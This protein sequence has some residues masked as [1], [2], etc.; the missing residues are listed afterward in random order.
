[1]NTGNLTEEQLQIL[2][3]KRGVSLEE[4]KDTLAA[5]GKQMGSIEA[6]PP[7]E[8]EKKQETAAGVSSSADTSLESQDLDPFEKAKYRLDQLK[9]TADDLK[10]ID[11]LANSEPKKVPIMRETARGTMTST[12]KFYDSY[13][14][15]EFI[16]QAKK[17][18]GIDDE[19]A[20][21]AEAK[22]LYIDAARTNLIDERA[23]EILEDYDNDSYSVLGRLRKYAGKFGSIP[24]VMGEEE[25]DAEIGKAKLQTYFNEK[26]QAAQEQTD[27]SIESIAKSISV[28]D[29]VDARLN[30]LQSKYKTAPESIT[31]EDVEDYNNLMETRNAAYS[32]YEKAKSKFDDVSVEAETLGQIADLTGRTYDNL[33]VATNRITAATL[34]IASGVASV[35]KELTPN[36][37]SHRI[38]GTDEYA[39][40]FMAG[41]SIP[42]GATKW[43]D[44]T[45]DYL[46]EESEKITNQTKKRQALGE[47]SS[48]EDF[49]E[50]G[51]DLFSEQAVNTAITAGL[52]GAGLAIVSA[53]AAGNKFREMDIEIEGGEKISPL[54]FYAT[55]IMHGLGEYVTEKVSLDQFTA[56]RKGL[57]KAF[58][59]KGSSISLENINAAQAIKNWGIQTN[60][61]G[62]AE[63]SSQLIGN[64]ADKYVLGKDI[65]L[66]DGLS[67]SYFSGAIMS[68][69][70]FNAPALASDLTKVYTTGAEM[71]ANN[72]R[73]KRIV[74]ITKEIN[75]LSALNAEVE[76]PNRSRAI[77][78]LQEE[79]DNLVKEQLRAKKVNEDRLDQLSGADKRKLIDIES[80]AYR[81][82]KR[83]D[84]INKDDSISEASKKGMIERLAKRLDGLENQKQS[85]L[86]ES[87]L[88]KE[89]QQSKVFQRKA[90]AEAGLDFEII[91]GKDKADAIK[92]MQAKIDNSNLNDEQKTKLRE[93]VKEFEQSNANGAE[94]GADLG[95]PMSVV[96]MQDAKQDYAG[97]GR[98][99]FSHE[100]SH[101]SIFRKLVDNDADMQAL[102]KDTEKYMRRNYKG[103]G[104]RL[105]RVARDYAGSDPAILAEEKLAAMV[106]YSRE[107]NV[108]LD[109]TIQ[110][111][112]LGHWRKMF[113]KGQI[114]SIENG[115][116]VWDA[117]TAFTSSFEQ[118]EL[119]QVTKGILE[120]KIKANTKK[121]AQDIAKKAKFSLSSSA[122]RA[123][124]KLD[125][126]QEKGDIDPFDMD[127]VDELPG[128]ISAQVQPYVN[129]GLQLDREEL[130]QDVMVRIYE[131][132]DIGKFDGRG[133]L[134]G[135]LNGRIKF[136]ILDAFKQNPAIV[137]D[138]GDV[139]ADGLQGKEVQKLSV[140]AVEETTTVQDKP[141]YRNL[142]Q[143]RIVSEEVIDNI[144]NKIK[145][146][147]RVLKTRMDQSVS[148]N[149]TVKPYIAEIRK[150][151]GKQADI[152]LKKAMGG[153]KDGQLRKFLLQNKAAI[154]E[155]MTTTY[156]MTAMPNAVQKK[157]NGVFTSDWKGKKID[158]ETVGTD[159]AGRTSGAEIV[160][161][162]PNAA[163]RLSD[164]DF[165]SNILDENGNPI[166]GRKESLAKAIAEE[167]SFDLLTQ[168]LENPQSEIR[169]AFENNQELLG[170]ELFDNYVT[171]FKRDA[172]RGNVKFSIKFDVTNNAHL[173]EAGRLFRLTQKNSLN[174]VIDED[175]NITEAYKEDFADIENLGKFVKNAYDLGLIIDGTAGG[176]L[177]QIKNSDKIPAEIK[178]Q[179][180]GGFTRNSPAE[181][182]QRVLEFA[183]TFSTALGA[184]VM[185]I[186]GFDFLGFHR[187]GLDAA[188]TTKETGQPAE[189]FEAKNSIEN[190]LESSKD[191]PA[192]LDLSK[193]APMNSKMG[194]MAKVG[195]ILNS[196]KYS[197]VQQRQ[198]EI[199]KLQNE[200]SDANKHNK[201]LFKHVINKL[202][203]LKKKGQLDEAAM[204]YVLQFQTNA[205]KGLRALTGLKYIT[206]TDG[207]LGK[208][209]GEHLA[210]NATT[211]AEI[212][213]LIAE[214]PN[215]TDSEIES[216]IKDII[217]FHDQ[218]IENRTALDGVD[219]FGKNNPFKDKRILAVG[220]RLKNVFTFD[221]QPAQP[222]IEAR[223]N[224]IDS[225][226]KF[227]KKVNQ[228]QLQ[229]DKDAI[230]DE[231]SVV[232]NDTSGLSDEFNN[233]V[234]RKKG[235]AAFKEFSRIQAQ[236][237]G[238]K[239]GRFKFFIAPS[240]DDF[241]GLVNYAFAG[242]GKQGE[243]DMAFFEEK[244]LTPYFKG[245]AAIDAMRQQ[246]KR[247]FKAV[248]KQFKDQ[249][250]KLNQ[251][252][253][254]SGFTFDHALRVYMWNRQGIEVEGL[255]KR[256]T[257][258]LLDAI[259]KNPDLVELA[260]ALLVVARRD[261]WPDPTE[262]WEGGSVLADLNSMTEK[263]GRKKFL[264]E[265]IENADAIFT[266]ANLNKIEALYGRNH[267][268]AIED[269]LYAMK[270]GTNRPSGANRQTN[271]W[272][273]W[274]NGST[275][276]IMFFNRRSALLQM[277]SFTNFVNWSDNNPVKAAAAFANQPQ[278][279]KDFAMIFNSDKLKERRGGLKQDVSDSE[280]A[281]VA[282]RSKN[283][284]QAVLAY[285]LKIGF[286]PTQIA[287]SMAIATGG[288]MF[289]R[290]RVNTYLKQG[291]DQKAAEEQAFLDFSKKS[292][293]A[294]QSSDPA[295]VSQ[296]QRSTLGRLIL[297]FANTPM[298]Y[299]R[300]MKKAGQDLINGRGNPVEHISKIAYYGVVQNFIFSALQSALFSLAFDDDEEDDEKAQAKAEK[301][302]IRVVNSMIDTILR[303]SGI[304]GAVAATLKNTIMEYYSQEK[305][306]FMADHT[307]TLLSAAGIS[308]PIQSKMRKLYS[309]IQT[310]R[311]EKDNVEARGWALTA[312]GKLN[313]GPNY[314][315]LGNVLSATT[316]VPMDRV[317]D[318]LKSIS[319]AL[320]A[321]NKAWQRIALALG[322]KTWDVGV[323]NEEADLIK[324]GAKEERKKKGVEKAKRTRAKTTQ[325]KR[326]A[327]IQAALRR[328]QQKFNN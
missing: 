86:T 309:A 270:N 78:R 98:S 180:L 321:R 325:S 249:Y 299:T 214:V 30:K 53:S 294:Q 1:M 106:E 77:A 323:R 188:A 3:Q 148:K 123:K 65:S 250:K 216:R 136:R 298:Q 220:D 36:Q 46:A 75:S 152:D 173:Q 327:D 55:G 68:G 280:I 233:I 156:L 177:K 197:T 222:A 208:T 39:P 206:V 255:S 105:D 44:N 109:K 326:D 297:A 153:K 284:P 276:A 131:A 205:A 137:E 305:K 178:S 149:V 318:E 56:A 139:D 58:D 272:L 91:E 283:S 159:N 26:Q 20:W 266:P 168:E 118:G 47:V 87:Q 52:P 17:N 95:L 16:P 322:W 286:T 237:R 165:L 7:V 97:R 79:A 314:S 28:I 210:D 103:I 256:D 230:A 290:N 81:T 313:L 172:E 262:Y 269:S 133:S 301:K 200:I 175:G 150:V 143:R 300:L 209:K 23:E 252:V 184:D 176:F 257:K 124:A 41:V 89:R 102:A 328:R 5:R 38:M 154:L 119:N 21:R 115:A 42:S 90:A 126:V 218:W 254:D 267:R 132:N 127:V 239:M 315:I 144:K 134:Y 24:S 6:T 227:S 147:V 212:A 234:E 243:K 225:R 140:E 190:K 74:D 275:G 92:Q 59:I 145:S 265:F 117:I 125:A 248:T 101:S 135:Y 289:Y 277:L 160:R 128:M 138:F 162:L 64:F 302:Q 63:A 83:V 155:N 69:L 191:L 253:E 186:L 40:V 245:I 122:A 32:S 57:N 215:L 111:K 80:D 241:R 279:W 295:L 310:K 211:M 247:D 96:S 223:S 88:S 181:V 259:E 287:D 238:K 202:V 76:N 319:E 285:L 163:T 292:D 226:I 317:V 268:E 113:P 158:R 129:K 50:F 2:A 320:D 183:E 164:A 204:I 288:A 232:E 261:A 229:K 236:L 203:E 37:L 73:S 71:K 221:M 167:L 199:S 66:A 121:R 93:Q 260:D 303:G 251:S 207:P 116:D 157:V 84:D 27:K 271:A 231:S 311:F 29:D 45:A 304:Y 43:L 312:D 120:G 11:D 61:E 293:E 228:E 35:A 31:P 12:G 306:G 85:I 187:R 33:E 217:E 10:N 110:G 19:E 263:I 161:R 107:M 14:Y 49:L 34:N 170:V 196:T 22:K 166:R 4:F 13:V 169:Q 182:K 281:D 192:N 278:Y 246:I 151:M 201:L 54:Q 62:I 195:R 258:L 142:I 189:Y 244:L 240:A 282:G 130:V 114:Q 99:T 146:N 9:L 307:Y 185:D 193:V 308:P 8:P 179:I 174:E 264:T 194:V 15:D 108:E 18:V 235:V 324:A 48:V 291:M 219:V 316:N 296:Q 51:L 171:E 72:E 224:A 94:L 273:N 141:Q 104:A 67:E 60:Q 242:K 213:E 100:V 25:L 198:A 70:G 274:I 112:M 82:K